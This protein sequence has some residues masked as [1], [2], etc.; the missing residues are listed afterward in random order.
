MD[1]SYIRV[2]LD[3]N[4]T[5]IDFESK[6]A[7]DEANYKKDE[8]L[9]KNWFDTFVDA[10]NLEEIKD[11]FYKAF[12]DD[13]HNWESHSNDIKCKNG[14]HKLIDF[15]NHMEEINGEKVIVSFG[16]ERFLK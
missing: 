10:V 9:G 5:I 4:A 7:Q 11:V 1:I 12:R 16:K 8:V 15:E 13:D 2:V 3:K 14:E 6:L